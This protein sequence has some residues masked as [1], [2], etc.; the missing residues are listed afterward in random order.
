MI[1]RQKPI[2]RNGGKAGR[3]WL[4]ARNKWFRL[5]PGEEFECYICAKY[6]T[7]PEVTLDHV[8]PRGS[9]PEL[10][11]EQSNLEACCGRCQTAKGSKSLLAYLNE[12]RAKGLHVT[13]YALA[14][15]KDWLR[16]PAEGLQQPTIEDGAKADV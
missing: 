4:R 13:A 16:D 15:V 9:H 5:H 7:R 1:V 2:N 6:L 10:R 8:K 12:R 11:Y 3:L 14:L